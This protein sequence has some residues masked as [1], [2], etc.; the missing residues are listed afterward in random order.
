MRY[1]AI[2]CDQDFYCRVSDK[3]SLS[4]T[5]VRASWFGLSSVKILGDGYIKYLTGPDAQQVPYAEVTN[6]GG[7]ISAH[8]DVAKQVT[9]PLADAANYVVGDRIALWDTTGGQPFGAAGAVWSDKIF[10]IDYLTGVLTM[11]SALPLE[12]VDGTAATVDNGD[13]VGRYTRWRL[14]L[15]SVWQDFYFPKLWRKIKNTYNW[16]EVLPTEEVGDA[17]EAEGL[18]VERMLELIRI[19]RD[20]QYLCTLD[21]DLDVGITTRVPGETDDW[22]IS[23]CVWH[24]NPMS[25]GARA[26]ARVEMTIDGTN[27]EEVPQ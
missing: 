26:P 19:H 14:D 7:V 21:L 25:S 5:V 8:N 15:A 1:V 24:L 3:K 4:G 18:A 9:I 17:S 22:L 13:E 2:R 10:A 16:L 27:Y 23:K 20:H 12:L 6:Q 11:T